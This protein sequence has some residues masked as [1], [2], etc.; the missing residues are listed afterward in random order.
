MLDK[1]VPLLAYTYTPDCDITSSS[2]SQWW[3]DVV[4]H[5]GVFKFDSSGDGNFS[6]IEACIIGQWS[7]DFCGGMYF[8]SPQVY[9]HRRAG[10][11]NFAISTAYPDVDC[12]W[13]WFDAHGAEIIPSINAI[14][15]QARVSGDEARNYMMHCLALSMLG[16]MYSHDKRCLMASDVTDGRMH[17]VFNIAMNMAGSDYVIPRTPVADGIHH[18]DFED[19]R[20]AHG[21]IH[22]VSRHCVH[23]YDPQTY[24]TEDFRN[25]NSGNDCVGMMGV[26]DW[27]RHNV[28]DMCDYTLDDDGECAHCGH[29]Q[30][31]PKYRWNEAVVNAYKNP[32]YVLRARTSTWSN[33]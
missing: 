30:D 20:L 24:V 1:I 14:T 4:R 28:C 10:F 26:L 13:D 16:T 33:G 32:E 7:R 15:G 5:W 23:M 29:E 3:Y 19:D 9:T 6:T 31:V 27:D 22:N 12:S 8:S 2:R 18:T 11:G 25:Y 21:G 17:R